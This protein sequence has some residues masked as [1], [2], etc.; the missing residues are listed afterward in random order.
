MDQPRT[1]HASIRETV[2]KFGMVYMFSRTNGDEIEP[3]E[4]LTFLFDCLTRQLVRVL[5]KVVK[6]SLCRA[7]SWNEVV[8]SEGR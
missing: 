7:F 4:S 2:N 8:Y 5:V 6:T 1:G 3:L